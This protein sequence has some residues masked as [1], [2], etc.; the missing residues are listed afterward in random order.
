[1]IHLLKDSIL[2]KSINDLRIGY[3]IDEIFPFRNIYIA[4]DDDFKDLVSDFQR[5]IKTNEI[6]SLRLS[7]DRTEGYKNI[8]SEGDC[9]LAISKDGSNEFVRDMVKIALKNHIDVYGVYGDF[10]S[11][12][13]LLSDNSLIIEEDFD[14]NLSQFLKKLRARIDGDYIEDIPDGRLVKSPMNGMIIKI[15]VDVGDEVKKG[16]KVFVI[17]AMKMENDILSEMDGVIT[18]ILV[19]E[20]DAVSRGDYI[21]GIF[22]GD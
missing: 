9:L 6:F 5:D 7:K 22:T 15:N 16:D 8:I 19:E 4:C 14:K 3:F 12:L 2:K 13:A 11:G 20:G 1:M 17:E 21:M 10:K 18:D